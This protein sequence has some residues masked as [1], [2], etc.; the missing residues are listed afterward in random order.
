M[1]IISI[2]AAVALP[3]L[4]SQIGKARQVEGELAI[5]TFFRA[6]QAYHFEKGTFE[7]NITSTNQ[8]ETT[9]ALGIAIDFEVYAGG[10]ISSSADETTITLGNPTVSLEKRVKL[11]EGE[12]EYEN[13]GFLQVACESINYGGPAPSADPSTPSGI[14]SCGANGQIVQ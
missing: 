14:P 6:Q 13:G 1:I 11:L 10:S 8:L 12:L 2:L 3:N 9:N 4:L 7:T 5:S